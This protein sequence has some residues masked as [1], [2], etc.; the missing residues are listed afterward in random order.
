VNQ[1]SIEAYDF[2]QRVASYDADMDLMH[3]NRPTMIRIALQ[4]LPFERSAPLWALDLGVGTGYF[5]GRFLGHFPNSRVL[6]LDG[7]GLMAD[8]A[9]A[10]LG[11][12]AGRVE[13]RIDDF[14]NLKIAL[15]GSPP[16]DVVFSSFALHHLDRSD[17]QAVVHEALRLLKPKGWFVNADIV[18]ADSPEMEK[19]I[20]E[21]RVA[22]ILERAGGRD[23]R[24]RDAA[25]TRTFL[26]ELEARD[27]DQ[28]LSM[29]EDLE[30]LRRAGLQGVSAI[31]LE[32]RELVCGGWK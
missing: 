25:M 26:D 3:P 20:Q 17:K 10:R 9:R 5:T 32:H 28:P 2:P 16:F 23:E 14:R 21:V 11:A 8:L 19:R 4:T 12:L 7:A 1:R 13:F 15:A 29:L 31:W 22:G 6:A 24:F 30:L 27:G 18:V